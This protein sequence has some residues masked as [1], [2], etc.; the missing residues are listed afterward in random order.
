PRWRG[1]ALL[2]GPRAGDDRARRLPA[3]PRRARPKRPLR[4]RPAA[5]DLR[6]REPR[7]RG[8]SDRA[9]AGAERERARPPH[10]PLHSAR[11]RAPHLPSPHGTTAAA[12]GC[13]LTQGDLMAT[14]SYTTNV[15]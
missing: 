13:A 1:D 15:A 7:A 4:S 10:R 9:G 8:S 11:P 3:P 12:G 5:V 2:V 6:G 14:V